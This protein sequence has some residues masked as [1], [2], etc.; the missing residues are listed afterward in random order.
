MRPGRVALIAS[1]DGVKLRRPVVPGD[2]LRLEVVGRTIKS[3][4][5][6]VSGVAKVGDALAA[7]AKLR[8][9]MVDADRAAGSVDR[10][11]ARATAISKAG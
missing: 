6:C 5:A 4:A 3:N 11:A 8:F 10:D 7:E 1:I 2:Q 9:V